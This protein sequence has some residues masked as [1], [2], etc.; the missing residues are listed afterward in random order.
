MA[1]FVADHRADP[2]EVHGIIRIDPKIRRLKDRRGEHDFVRA[3]V[4]VGID[5]L[6]GH[7][8]LAAIHAP[9]KLCD[10]V[11]MGKRRDVSDGGKE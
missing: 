4:V 7:V 10:L 11:V 2:T 5:R 9:P 8:P 3:R 1:D 6:R